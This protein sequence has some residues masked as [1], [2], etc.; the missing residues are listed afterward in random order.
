MVVVVVVDDVVVVD[1]DAARVDEV[2]SGSSPDVHAETTSISPENQA[3]RS[4]R[5]RLLIIAIRP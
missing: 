1:V 2:V 3:I 5:R 4:T